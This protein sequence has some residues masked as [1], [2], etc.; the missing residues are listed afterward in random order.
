MWTEPAGVSATVEETP[1]KGGR[2]RSAT[3][4]RSAAPTCPR[5]TSSANSLPRWEKRQGAAGSLEREAGT[6]FDG[7]VESYVLES[8]RRIITKTGAVSG[9][10]GS[11]AKHAHLDRYIRALP[12]RFG[13]L[14]AGPNVAFIMP[15]GRI[16]HGIDAERF[17]DILCAYSDA[18][19]AGELRGNQ[20]H[21]ALHCQ[22]LIRQL[23]KTG[24]AALIDEACGV[25]RAPGAR[26]ATSAKRQA[27]FL[28]A[29]SNTPKADE[30]TLKVIDGFL[31]ARR[32]HQAWCRRPGG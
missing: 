13:Y 14:A 15:G 21:L 32:E 8:G 16:G 27:L 11:G 3:K 5:T 17:V 29:K 26:G 25:R 22:K 19:D 31:A 9:I 2:W 7:L 30:I 4:A 28:V 1:A 18:A 10:S 6:L 20:L 23:A 24:I 12:S